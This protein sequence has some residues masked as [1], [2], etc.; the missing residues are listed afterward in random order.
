MN[1][2]ILLSLCPWP[3]HGC[4]RLP[5]GGRLGLGLGPR[6]ASCAE[7]DI[8]AA[9]QPHASFLSKLH[10]LPAVQVAAVPAAP[11]AAVGAAT[12][13]A[14]QARACKRLHCVAG[15][16]HTA[17]RCV[18]PA[19]SASWQGSRVLFLALQAKRSQGGTSLARRR[20]GEESEG[21]EGL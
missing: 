15:G 18:L 20:P 11:P 1:A 10:L 17:I 4:D 3:G 6:T 13:T 14:E 7:L 8:G 9:Q 16:L 12:G 21:P 5:K 19:G 2:A